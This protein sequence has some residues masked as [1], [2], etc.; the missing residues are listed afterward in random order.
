MRALILAALLLLPGCSLFKTPDP[1]PVVKT[2]YKTI[3]VPGPPVPCRIPDIKEPA[4]LVAGLKKT[5]DIHY[6]VKVILADRELHKAHQTTLETAVKS[7]NQN[8]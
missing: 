5:D 6:K 8:N 4:D 3:E 7:C 1:A 2:E